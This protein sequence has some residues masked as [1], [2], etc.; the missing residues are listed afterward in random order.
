M[1]AQLE[2]FFLLSYLCLFQWKPN[3][4]KTKINKIETLYTFLMKSRK[5]DDGTAA[6]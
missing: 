1:S 6:Y 3:V 4:G 5:S 2:L